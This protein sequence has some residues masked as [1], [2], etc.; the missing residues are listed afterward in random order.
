MA[1]YKTIIASDIH[2]P[3][4]DNKGKEFLKRLKNQS[5]D[6]LILN[7]DIVD[8]RHI[9]LFGWW[10]RKH[11]NRRKE[12]IELAKKQWTKIKYIIGNHDIHIEKT[13]PRLRQ[14]V[15][16]A[17]DMIYTSGKKKYYIC[18]GQ[19]FDKLEGKF[20]TRSKITFCGGTF[21]YRF[22]RTFNELTKK[23]WWKYVSLIR[24]IKRIIKTLMVGWSSSFHKKLIATCKAKNVQGIICGHL[25]KAE[26]TPIGQY[27]YMNSGDRIELCTVLV[28][29]A[30]NKRE[31]ID[32]HL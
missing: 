18:H 5:F 2:M 17:P 11:V 26:K 22:N 16:I 6:Q 32:T 4:P 7:G 24:K 28:Q 31:I 9:S 20:T 12:I 3:S 15:D 13:I 27:E 23:L 25:H 19:Q 29:K 30:D 21:L 8:G 10:K 14:E 1:H